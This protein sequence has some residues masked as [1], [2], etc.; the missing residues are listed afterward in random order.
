MDDRPAPRQV[1]SVEEVNELLPA[2][3]ELLT[4]LQAAREQLLSAQET[5]SERYQGGARS[6]G[7][8]NPAGATGQ[9]T[10]QVEGAQAR[11][12]RAVH[13]IAELGG[14]LKDLDRGMVDFR[15]ERDGRVVYLCWLMHEPEVL[16][17]HELDGGFGGRQP[18]D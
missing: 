10:T 9:L 1:F 15:T 13:A 17:W 6:N 16:F 3:R 7:H 4:D 14:E 11:I 12:S 2:L 18:L 5:L 8:V